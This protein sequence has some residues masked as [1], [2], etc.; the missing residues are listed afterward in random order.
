MAY[1]IPCVCFLVPGV[2]M[3][4]TCICC[5]LSSKSPHNKAT[6]QNTPVGWAYWMKPENPRP[7]C[8]HGRKSPVGKGQRFFF[9][10]NPLAMQS[11]PC[12]RWKA[13]RTFWTRHANCWVFVITWLGNL[14]RVTNKDSM[15]PVLCSKCTRGF[16]INF[17]RFVWP[18]DVAGRAL[19]GQLADWNEWKTFAL[20]FY[21]GFVAVGPFWSGIFW[22]CLVGSPNWSV[23]PRPFSWRGETGN[24]NCYKKVT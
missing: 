17:D 14:I 24:S 12:Q 7:K 4:P 8:S 13:P 19:I 10:F 2:V 5:D 6:R 16:I 3:L 23:S 21:S 9:H 18:P 22:L 15:V 1:L 11:K 20:A